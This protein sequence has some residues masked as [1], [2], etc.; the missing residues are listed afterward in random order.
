[1]ALFSCKPALWTW[2]RLTSLSEPKFSLALSLMRLRSSPTLMSLA[3][4]KPPATVRAPLVAVVD[5]VALLTAT[6]PAAEMLMASVSPAEP[7][8]ASLG[9]TMLVPKVAVVLV[10]DSLSVLLMLRLIWESASACSSPSAL[11]W[12]NTSASLNCSLAVEAIS[13]LVP[14]SV[15]LR[16][17]ISPEDASLYK[18]DPVCTAMSPAVLKRNQEKSAAVMFPAES[19]ASCAFI[20][21]PL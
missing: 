11:E 10:K 1:M 19:L 9:I 18:P 2:V 15:T 4:P 13:R 12:M 6:T 20:T 7:I 14:S 16:T 5:S 21:G 17:L 3:T 8:F